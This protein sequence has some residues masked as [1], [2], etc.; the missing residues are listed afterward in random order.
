[1]TRWVL[2][3]IDG[4]LGL[5]RGY[6]DN[7]RQLDRGPPCEFFR[8]MRL[9]SDRRPHASA[10]YCLAARGV[11]PGAVVRC[12]KTARAGPA[13]AAKLPRTR[14][15]VVKYKGLIWPSIHVYVTMAQA[16]G[17]SRPSWFC[18]HVVA[19]A[20]CSTISRRCGRARCSIR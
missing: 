16:L 2:E 20:N 9:S 18:F 12:N 4:F 5:L 14:A 7:A 1:M 11:N 8:V 13:L 3:A 19:P 6:R 15:L 17:I 10:Q